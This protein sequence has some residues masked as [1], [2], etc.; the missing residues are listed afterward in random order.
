MRIRQRRL[1][2]FV[3]TVALVASTLPFPGSAPATATAPRPADQAQVVPAA[4]LVG[5]Y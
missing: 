1:L 2:A 5:D 3:V 4:H